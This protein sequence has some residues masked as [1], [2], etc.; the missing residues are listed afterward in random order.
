MAGNTEI[1]LGTASTRG[2][3]AGRG[4][5]TALPA[6][7]SGQGS[8]TAA[9]PPDAFAHGALLSAFAVA[10][11]AADAASARGVDEDAFAS[12][13]QE[14]AGVAIQPAVATHKTSATPGNDNL[15]F[16]LSVMTIVSLLANRLARPVVT[17]IPSPGAA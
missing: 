1:A 17:P 3:I 11:G 9:P 2:A 16:T 13:G 5:G 14:R 10:Q 7:A 15:G 4:V 8:A 6:F 12:F